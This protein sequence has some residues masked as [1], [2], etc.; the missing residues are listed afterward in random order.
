MNR[1]ELEEYVG[2]TAYSMGQVEKDYLQHIVLGTL[3]RRLGGALVFKGGT[4][5]QK[6]GVIHRF[7]EDLDFTAREPVSASQLEEASVSAL[8]A[9]N[10]PPVVDRLVDDERTVGFR[11]KVQGPLHKGPKTLCSIA[12]EVSR[13]EEVVRRPARHEVGPP[14]RD[15]LPYFVLV[16]DLEE[17]LAEK[18]RA[19]ATRQK[20]RDLYDL[21]QLAKLDL[22]L[23]EGL[24]ERK[25]LYYGVPMGHA[26]VLE[27]ARR[28]E[29]GWDSELRDQVEAVPPFKGAFEALERLL[30]QTT[31]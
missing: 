14:Y 18:V 2:V 25:L 10:F 11:V 17:V 19:L 30:N 5:L 12:L 16:M 24:V 13:R 8:R 1:E 15:V 26:L 22:K 3:S 9:F 21:A 29:A 28:L 31:M 20:A 6:L 23:D 7:S 27:R 4:A